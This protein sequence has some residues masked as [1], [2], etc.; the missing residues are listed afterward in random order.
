MFEKVESYA[1]D[2][3]LSLVTDF[4]NDSRKDKTNLSI[5]YYY[6]EHG[7]IPQ[8]E[9]IKVARDYLYNNQKQAQLYLPMSGLPS[10]CQA[11]Q[12]L[13]FGEN[14]PAYQDKRIATIQTLGGSG[15]LKVGADFLFRYFPT[16]EVWVSDPTWENHIAIF[17]GAGFKVNKYPYFD[18]QTC[19][20]KFEAMLATLNK[21]P[22]KSIVLLHPCCHN[23]TGADLTHDEWDKVIEVLLARDLIP[24]MDIAYQGFGES[25]DDDVYAIKKAAEKKLC[26]LVS[27][28]FSKTFSLYG[29]RVGGLSVLCEN[30]EAANRIL[31][32]L[33]ATVRRNYSSPAAYGAQLVSHVLNN[34][35]LKMQWYEEVALMRERIALMRSTL[36]DSLKKAVPDRDFDYLV[37]QRGMFSYTGFTQEQVNYLRKNFA[38]YLVG[39]GRMCVAGLNHHN[40]YRVAEAFAALK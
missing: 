28:S 19:G 7:V 29:E 40:I 18:P 30:S 8:L 10:Y 14:N 11:I 9:C 26:G 21:L 33:Q 27:N 5:G 2:P 12:S 6:D 34:S 31:G 16:S 37:K 20:V 13:L 1:G 24:F 35:D 4:N 17:N 3:I 32:Q 25:I 38:V 23:P 22:A 39:S 36:V 15:A